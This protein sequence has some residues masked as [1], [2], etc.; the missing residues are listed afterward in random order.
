MHFSFEYL[1]CSLEKEIFVDIR[2]CMVRILKSKVED[3]I[4]FFHGW[5]LIPEL[6]I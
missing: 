4:F 1:S 3:Q 6:L 2:E 5:L